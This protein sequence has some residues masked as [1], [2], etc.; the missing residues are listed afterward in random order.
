MVVAERP[1]PPRGQ[2]IPGVRVRVKGGYEPPVVH[3]RVG[4]PLRI[5]FRREETASC[6]EHVVFPEFGTSTMLPP[7]E[8]VAI[9]LVPERTGE[10]EFTC[11]MGMLRGRLL[12]TG[13][14]T[15]RPKSTDP[16]LA[17]DLRPQWMRGM[18]PEH[19]D[20]VLLAFV[21]WLCSLPLLLLVGVPLLGWRAGGLLALLWFGV[22]ATACFAVCVRRVRRPASLKRETA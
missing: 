4:E 12:V 6:S 15:E 18:A 17:R 5:V 3:G 19:R 16:A 10:Y 8:D 14:G 9:E 22:A 11:Q 20:T 2:R 7:F 21:A 13:N 1:S